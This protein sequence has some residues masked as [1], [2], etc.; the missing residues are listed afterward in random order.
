MYIFKHSLLLGCWLFAFPESPKFLIECGEMDE[1]LD[2]LGH[3]F[4]RNTGKARAEYPVGLKDYTHLHHTFN[5][6][7]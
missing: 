4:E 7:H 2:V 1:A 6:I 5:Q 3:I